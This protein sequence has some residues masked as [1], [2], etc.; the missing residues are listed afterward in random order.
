MLNICETCKVSL[1]NCFEF[2][3]QWD[4]SREA[5]QKILASKNKYIEE[6]GKKALAQCANCGKVFT[7][8]YLKIHLRI[9]NNEKP[10]EC[11]QCGMTFNQRGNLTLHERMHSQQRPYQCEF[12]SKQ[13]STS[14]NLKAHQR[15][16]SDERKF[17]CK[18][19][20]MKFKSAAELKNHCSTHTNIR[21]FVCD[22]CDKSFYKVAYLNVHIRTVHEGEKRHR[23]TECHK[24]FSNTSNLIVHRR[25]HTNEKPFQCKVCMFRFSQSSALN[26]HLRQ[27]Q[28]KHQIAEK[29]ETNL[30]ALSDNHEFHIAS[31]VDSIESN[32][33]LNVDDDDESDPDNQCLAA[34]ILATAIANEGCQENI[35]IV[36][37]TNSYHS[38]A[39]PNSYN[40]H[41]FNEYYYYRNN[42]VHP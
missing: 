22:Q 36:D 30:E 23:C 25:S 8:A 13:F 3:R 37:R 15:S 20:E 24:T 18:E 10:Y 40:N 4:S 9:H 12:C 16:H 41:S 26:R 11:L 35:D 39:G 34:S 27:H 29:M 19:C 14:S 33:A 1:R 2:K 42:S 32:M 21:K 38:C 17:N 6:K 7:K 31:P 5:L 28:D